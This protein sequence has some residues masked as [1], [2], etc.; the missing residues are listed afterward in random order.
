MVNSKIKEEFERASDLDKKSTI[1]TIKEMIKEKWGQ[2]EWI[3][4]KCPKCNNIQRVQ[5][6]LRTTCRKCMSA[7]KIYPSNSI[8][9]VVEVPKGK[10]YLL[11]QIRAL[12]KFGRFDELL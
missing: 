2:L 10:L 8:S 7:Y 12:R 1:I 11:R 9:R 3:K 6:D 4:V 5:T